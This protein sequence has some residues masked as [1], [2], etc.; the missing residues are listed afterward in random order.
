MCGGIEVGVRESARARRLTVKVSTDRPPELVVPVGTGRREIERT[1]RRHRDWIARKTEEMERLAA[2]RP[3]LGLDRP[4]F[5]WLHGE[6]LAILRDRGARPVAKLRDGRLLVAGP[7]A[8]ASDAI[9]RWYRREAR[10]RIATAVQ[11]EAEALAVRPG[12]VSIRDP[13]TRWGSCTSRGSLSFSWRLL[14]APRQVLDYVVIHE[15]CHLRE[16]NHS[17]AFWRLLD[18]AR[19]D[20]RAQAGWLRRHGWELGTYRPRLA[21]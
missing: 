12:Q 17:P 14:L 6:P 11:R 21:G 3:R 8:Q 1:L 13:G 19:P 4:G 15:L 2:R 9:E 7:A 5:V 16:L 18:R 10:R 20:W